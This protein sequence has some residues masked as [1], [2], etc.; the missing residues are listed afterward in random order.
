MEEDKGSDRIGG[1][2]NKHSRD[3]G[4]NI[5]KKW[6]RILLNQEKEGN[7]K[8]LESGGPKLICENL[9][10]RDFPL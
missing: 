10:Y 5:Y 8:F 6:K 2:Q 9:N 3:W 1:N 7:D 4:P